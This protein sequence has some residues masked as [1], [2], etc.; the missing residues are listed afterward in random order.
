MAE[1]LQVLAEKIGKTLNQEGLELLLTVLDDGRLE[2][3]EH[4]LR[5]YYTQRFPQA[6][7]TFFRGK[8]L[9]KN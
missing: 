5:T 4:A 9:Y 1:T 7:R 6:A 3:F 8:A 2:L